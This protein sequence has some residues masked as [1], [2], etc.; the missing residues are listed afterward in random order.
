MRTFR[1]HSDGSDASVRDDVLP[2]VRKHK[3]C[4]DGVALLEG[5]PHDSWVRAW[6]ECERGDYMRWVLERA[7][8][9]AE[10]KMWVRLCTVACAATALEHTTDPRVEAALVFAWRH[11]KAAAKA[12]RSCADIV[13]AFFPHAPVLT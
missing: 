12:R 1:V 13:R 7:I 8:W 4:A 10:A 6:A 5:L 11:A 3:A 2:W 9:G